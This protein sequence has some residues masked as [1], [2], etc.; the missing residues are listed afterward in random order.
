MAHFRPGSALPTRRD[1]EDQS[2]NRPGRISKMQAGREA[3]SHVPRLVWGLGTNDKQ[4]VPPPPRRP[5]HWPDA[6]DRGPE[7]PKSVLSR[8][9]F[10]NRPTILRAPSRLRITLLSLFLICLLGAAQGA[11][12]AYLLVLLTPDTAERLVM[13][14]RYVVSAIGPAAAVL[15]RMGWQRE[16][17]GMGAPSPS[18]SASLV[19]IPPL[20]ATLDT[21]AKLSRMTETAAVLPPAAESKAPKDSIPTPAAASDAELSALLQKAKRELA[22]RKL[23][24]PPLDNALESYRLLSSRWPREK[25]VTELGGAIGLAFW[26]MGNEAKAAGNWQQALHYFE[27]VNTLPPLPLISVPPEESSPRQ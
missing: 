23:E 10:P 24:Q 19:P 15:G 25:G 18:R 8:R 16:S 5:G 11:G 17:G 1:L 13:P 20:E 4:N 6:A 7:G 26:T 14:I 12:G 22:E 9:S 2:D 27:L 21:K 3:E